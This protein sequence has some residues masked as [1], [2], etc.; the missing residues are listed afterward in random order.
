[1]SSREDILKSIREHTQTRYEMPDLD[2]H[3]LMTYPDKSEQFGIMLKQVGG[4]AVVLE[5]GADINKVIRDLYPDAQRIASDLPEIKI[6]TF[7]PDDVAAAADLNGT[8]VAVIR[9]CLGV[10]ENGAVWIE[11]NVKYRSLYFISE[12]LVILLD[13]DKLVNNMAEAYLIVNTGKYG[14]GT[15]ISGPSKTADIEQALV[16]GAHGARGVTVILE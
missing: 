14:F 5:E 13:K 16:F 3:E 12:N 4:E 6:A 11:Q 1:M 10:A 2:S 9:G 15:F 7:N 8:D